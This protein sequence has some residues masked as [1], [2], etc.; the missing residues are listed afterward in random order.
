MPGSAED[1][2]IWKK[3]TVRWDLNS[4]RDSWDS[5]L[6]EGRRF[7]VGVYE[8][9]RAFVEEI[10]SLSLLM[11]KN[12]KLKMVI[13]SFVPEPIS[14]VFGFLYAYEHLWTFSVS[15]WICLFHV[16][17]SWSYIF[18]R[19]Y[20][21]LRPFCK[22]RNSSKKVKTLVN[23]NNDMVFHWLNYLELNCLFQEK[24]CE[25]GD[26]DNYE[27]WLLFVLRIYRFV[28]MEWTEER[29]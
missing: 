11:S 17:G 8:M 15:V 18:G 2:G 12:L 4:E 1:F 23:L 16:F 20:V 29:K 25:W 24:K 6:E 28:W 3:K 14:S 13:K 22:A 21:T 7:F 9:C 5:S 27:H 19:G 26:T 10:V